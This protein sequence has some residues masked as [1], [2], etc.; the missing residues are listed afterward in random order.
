MNL[1]VVED[2]DGRWQAKSEVDEKTK[3]AGLAAVCCGPKIILVAPILEN[4][5]HSQTFCS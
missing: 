5:R 2:V 3:T 4:A 1:H